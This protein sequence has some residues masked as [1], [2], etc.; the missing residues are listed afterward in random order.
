MLLMASAAVQAQTIKGK[1]TDA[2]T[3]EALIGATV[4]I[5]GI[6]K[7][8]VTDMDGVFAVSGLGRNTKHNVTI[9]YVGY[10]ALTVENVQSKADDS[11]DCPAYT[12]SADVT[13]LGEVSV[14]AVER[15]NTSAA[16]IQLAK[17]SAVV[18]N[19]ISAQDIKLS[20]DANAG[21]V[22]RRIPGVS[23]IEDKFVMVR[24]LS[25]RY[26]NV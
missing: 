4:E 17:N 19:N 8:A 13:Q 3:G 22:I 20:Q 10:K 26:N 21:E 6:G 23:L 25:Q 18:V 2:Q 14:T 9:N 11:A 5:V 7:R 24:G 1:V 12:M 16:V 15:K